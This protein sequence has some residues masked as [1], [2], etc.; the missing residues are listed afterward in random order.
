MRKVRKCSYLGAYLHA[1]LQIRVLLGK[2]RD[3]YLA[4]TNVLSDTNVLGSH[5]SPY[6]SLFPQLISSV[7]SEISAGKGRETQVME[8]HSRVTTKLCSGNSEKGKMMGSGKLY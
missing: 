8:G 1:K 2:R 7:F 5:F 3:G 6:S 4:T